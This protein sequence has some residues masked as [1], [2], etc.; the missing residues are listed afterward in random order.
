MKAD[1]RQ[2]SRHQKNLWALLTLQLP[3]RLIHCFTEFW[4]H[5]MAGE[6]EIDEEENEFVVAACAALDSLS[7]AVSSQKTFEGSLSRHA[8]YYPAI[9][10]KE[11][12]EIAE[13]LSTDLEEHLTDGEWAQDQIDFLEMLPERLSHLQAQVV[14]QMFSGNGGQAIPAYTSTLAWVRL[15]LKETLEP[16]PVI[17]F[18]SIDPEEIPAKLARRVRNVEGQITRVEEGTSKLDEKVTLINSAYQAASDL[19]A[20]IEDLKQGNAAVETAKTES[21]AS[22][23][24]IEENQ[25]KSAAA[26]GKVEKDQIEAEKL[27]V[28][29]GEAYRIT[30]TKGLAGAFDTRASKLASSMWV[31]VVGLLAALA[32]ASIL[33]GQRVALLS[34]ALTGQEPKWG[35]IWLNLILSAL[36]V[37]APLWFAWVATKQISQRFRLAED[38]AFK[39][40][41]AKAYEG[42]RREAASLDEQF[43]SRLF[44]SAL[45]RLEEAPLRLVDGQDHGSPWHELFASPKVQAAMDSVPELQLRAEALLRDALAAV[46]RAGKP[47]QSSTTIAEAKPDEQT[48]AA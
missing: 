2:Q 28:Q 10:I 29:C 31:W 1:S 16:P 22:L 46:T 34:G 30:T 33:G 11:L 26:L 47:P 6:V 41:V 7:A 25:K 21:A 18:E 15:R 38:Y 45:T 35:A 3:W 40:S 23:L 37:A 32:I 14:P 4:E 5:E 27:V 13:D 12:S 24:A 43:S 20:T 9:S 44:S 48:K 39:A 36:S 19:P 17:D 8:W 42:Y